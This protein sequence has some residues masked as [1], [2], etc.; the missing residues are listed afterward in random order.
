MSVFD[1]LGIDFVPHFCPL[2]YLPFIARSGSLKS[3]PE[4]KAGGFGDTHFRSKSSKHDISRGFGKYA[5]LTLTTEPKIVIA[6]LKGGFPH[7]SV[8]VPVAA[9]D[10]LNFD[11]CRY[12]VAMFRRKRTSVLGGFPESASYGRYY[13]DKELPI[14]RDEAHKLANERG[15]ASDRRGL[16]RRA[17][18]R[19]EA[20]WTAL[21]AA[22]SPAN[23]AA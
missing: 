7:V 8:K 9:F 19:V 23:C 20:R 12:N 14:T 17:G 18:H 13:E 1:S 21:R 2:H 3:K 4:Y 16:Q 10:D 15:L 22:F 11:L 6:K 5:F